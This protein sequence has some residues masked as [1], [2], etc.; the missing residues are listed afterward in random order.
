MVSSDE[1]AWAEI[2]MAPVVADERACGLRAAME[3]CLI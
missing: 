1:E 3:G 2:R